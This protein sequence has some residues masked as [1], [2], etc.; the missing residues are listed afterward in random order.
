MYHT[1]S[2]KVHFQCTVLESLGEVSVVLAIYS[3]YPKLDLISS[4]AVFGVGG[5]ELPH[6][7]GQV[8]GR[9]LC[10]STDETLQYC[11]MDESI[12]VLWKRRTIISYQEI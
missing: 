5:G 1:T 6:D 12:L 11:I 3:T 2:D 7:L 8:L 9:D 10:L 4:L